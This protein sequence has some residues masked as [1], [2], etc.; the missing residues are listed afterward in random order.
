MA[1]EWTLVATISP[2]S[3]GQAVAYRA[4]ILG[5][6]VVFVARG[7]FYKWNGATATAISTTT[8]FPN[9]AIGSVSPSILDFCV[10]NGDLFAM[11]GY[12]DGI[13]QD[14]IYRYTSGTTWVLDTTLEDEDGAAFPYPH[15]GVPMPTNTEGRHFW[16]DTDGTYMF[17]VARQAVG[18]G[19]TVGRMIH[20]N[21]S[22]VYGVGTMPG[23]GYDSPQPQL[24]GQSKGYTGAML[25]VNRTGANTYRAI[26]GSP[27]FSNLSGSD[28][29]DKRLIG[30]ADGKSFWS[31]VD[32]SN[33]E[34]KYSTDW[35]VTLTA[36]GNIENPGTNDRSGFVF[37]D[38]GE[39]AIMLAVPTTNNVAQNQQVYVWDPNTNT[40]VDD[41]T[42][43]SGLATFLRIYD[44]FVLNNNLY[45]LS[46][47]NT[48][49]SVDIWTAGS[50]CVSK[51]YYGIEVP[52]YTSDLPFCG[53]NPGG[54][55]LAKSGLVVLG[56]DGRV[57]PSVVYGGY[58]YTG[59]WVDISGIVPT[60][61]A[62]T[63]IKFL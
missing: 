12:A 60:G 40:F 53:V 52:V 21:T 16:M 34:L 18:A 1:R 31:V 63:S 57:G 24:V 61:T 22:G 3:L 15:V 39:G 51:F 56:T 14:Y 43:P 19:Q 2:P 32:G 26:Q 47:S 11:V 23:G 33:W 50:S 8:T 6:S 49:N 48:A 54:L 10:F 36:L 13:E 28:V 44:F 9:S 4:L 58:P 46:N 30:Y 17:I 59:E 37:K 25:G 29:G 5:D 7:I 45:L 41:G 27:N 62:V 35:G 38:L 55:A 42:V 20:R